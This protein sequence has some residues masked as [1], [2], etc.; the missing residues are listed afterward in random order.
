MKNK[1]FCMA[2]TAS[3][4]I[5]MAVNAEGRN[6]GVVVNGS[7][8]NFSNYGN[9]LPVIEDDYTLIPIR[10]AVESLGAEVQWDED[11]QN[12]TISGEKKVMTVLL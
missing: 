9:V 10:A 2:V 6:I 5:P 3:M 1:L 4:I 7:Q 12:V 8:V 11:S